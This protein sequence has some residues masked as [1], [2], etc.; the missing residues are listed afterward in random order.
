[1]KRLL[2]PLACP[3]IQRFIQWTLN[4]TD[5]NRVVTLTHLALLMPMT[6]VYFRRKLIMPILLLP[7]WRAIQTPV[8]G[9]VNSSSP[10]HTLLWPV[11]LSSD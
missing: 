11:Q 7:T 3:S 2:S 1:M 9:P 10:S 5:Q 4:K 8:P 6:D